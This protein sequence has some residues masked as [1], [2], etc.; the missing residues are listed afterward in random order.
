MNSEIPN[1]IIEE[2]KVISL[3]AEGETSWIIIKKQLLLALPHALRKYFSTRDPKTKKQNINQ[4]EIKLIQF[5]EDTTGI[6][7]ELPNE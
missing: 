3:V 7:L 4:F 5:Y 2:L 6:Q 1:R